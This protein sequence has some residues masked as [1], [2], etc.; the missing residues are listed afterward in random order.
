MKWKLAATALGAALLASAGIARADGEL[1]IYNW[2]NYTSPD[3]IKK[4]EEK[5]KVK[6]TVTDYDS[7][8]TALAKIRQG[9]SGFDIVVPSASFVPIWIEEGLLLETEPSKMENFKNMDPKWVDVP[10]DPG[11]KYTVPWQWG[12][13][14]VTVNTSVYKGDVNTSAIFL[15]PPP[16]LV[17]KVNVV[18]EMAD[19]M[20]LAIRYVGGEPCTG[21]KEVLKKVRDALVAAKPK[22]I[23]M[24]YGTVEKF[25]KGDFAASVDWNGASFRARLQNKD[26]V[27]GYPKEGYPIWM[28]NLAV[29]K[30]AKNVENAKLFQNFIMDPENAALISSFARYANGIKGSEAFMPE[31]MKT[32]PEVNI[33]A[34]FADK[35]K[36]MLSCAP[37]VQALYTRIWTELQK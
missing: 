11:R 12:T 6:V 30:D 16:E 23:S 5:Y 15:D 2:G 9:G 31:D 33:P 13:T 35:G 18:P 22:W 27:Y 26:M 21:D 1:N 7:N 36:F 17:G 32:A 37:D 28:D 14:G 34:E 29:L 19:V 25:A 3:L 24:D 4:F 8:D 20:H 10:F